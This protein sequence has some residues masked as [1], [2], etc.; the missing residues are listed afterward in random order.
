MN[1]CKIT[2]TKLD[3]SQEATEWIDW[4][5][6]MDY[7][8]VRIE[9]N[10]NKAYPYENYLMKIDFKLKKERVRRPST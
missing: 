6:N 4:V 10:T 2:I 7:N 5:K 8:N 3:L 9:A 1:Y